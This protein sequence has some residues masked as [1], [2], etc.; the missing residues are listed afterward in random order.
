MTAPKRQRF[1]IYGPIHK[2]L[3]RAT[4]ELVIAVGRADPADADAARELAGAVRNHL[5]ILRGHI[6]HERKFVHAALEAVSPTLLEIIERDHRA[7]EEIFGEL[8]LKV[9]L[10]RQAEPQA[11]A[12]ACRDL[13]LGLCDFL[14]EDLQ[15]LAQE[16]RV[17]WPR[18]CAELSDE[19][20]AEIERRIVASM[21]ADEQIESFRLM[22]AAVNPAERL[23]LMRSVAESAPAD[24]TWM[25]LNEAAGPVLSGPEFSEL[26]QALFGSQHLEAAE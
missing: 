13:Y 7:H 14:A 10:Y 9:D 12:G 18:L 22:M 1:D 20:L 11:R 24:M 4:M 26:V 5:R 21:S 2:G 19:A 8:E 17:V 23:R 6:E 3:R 15:H 25:F 16:E